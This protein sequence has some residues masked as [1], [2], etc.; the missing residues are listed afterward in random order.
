MRTSG[1]IDPNMGFKISMTLANINC[2][3]DQCQKTFQTKVPSYYNTFTLFLT[4]SL[5]IF[6][7]FSELREAGFEV[8]FINVFQLIFFLTFIS[9]SERIANPFGQR[10]SDLMSEDKL[11]HIQKLLDELREYSQI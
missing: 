7:P 4:Y 9:I 6:L 10:E 2:F 11:V 5:C 8:A 3:A 1:I